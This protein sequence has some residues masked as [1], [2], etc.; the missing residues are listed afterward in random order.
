MNVY[1]N[2]L[3]LKSTEKLRWVYIFLNSISMDGIHDVPLLEFPFNMQHSSNSCWKDWKAS[4]GL[5]QVVDLSLVVKQD[6]RAMQSQPLNRVM[7][8]VKHNYHDLQS[9]SL[10]SNQAKSAMAGMG[11]PARVG[12]LEE[13]VGK[14]V[15][16][17]GF[18]NRS[19]VGFF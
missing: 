2:K 10:Y 3:D 9:S 5:P 16:K 11:S 14:V 12:E 13:G 4:C 6:Q 1:C 8:P 15:L 17:T 18:S 19:P 7:A